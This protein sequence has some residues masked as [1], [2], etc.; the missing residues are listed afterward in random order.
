MTQPHALIVF[1]SMFGNTAA[2]AAAVADGLREGGVLVAVRHVAEAAALDDVAPELLVVG[3]PTHAFS[4]SR[5]ATRAEA[6]AKGA[7]A[8]AG[9]TGMRE[10]LGAAGRR[11]GTG[12]VAVAF[13]TRVA[14]VRRLPLSAARSATRMLRHKGYARVLSCEGFAVADVRGALLP[15]EL[16]RA[17]Q[18]GARLA[19]ELEVSRPAPTTR[20]SYP[21]V[22][23]NGW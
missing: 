16:V 4:L 22:D 23:P 15:G 17:R 20:S 21:T 9:R 12:R 13:D 6:V 14:S 3:A 10:W 18:W 19:G 7:P 8:A 5:P 2:V 11:S 1:E